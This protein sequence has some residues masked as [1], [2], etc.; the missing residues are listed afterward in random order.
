MSDLVKDVQKQEIS[1]G[2]IFLFDLEYISGS[3]ARFY[4]G[5]SEDSENV[6]FRDSSGNVVTYEALPIEMEGIDIASDGSYN[7]PVISVANL[8]SIFS[9]AIGGLSYEELI[10]KR[11]TRRTTLEKYLVGGTGDSGAGNAPVEFPKATYVIDRIKSK[12]LLSVSFELAAPFDLAGVTLPRRVI[13]GGSCPFKYRGAA[14]NVSAQDKIG[15]CNWSQTIIASDVSNVFMNKFDEYIVPASLF[16]GLSNFSGT[17]TAGAYYITTESQ[18]QV[19]KTS[20]STQN[21]T[22]YWQALTATSNS[23]ADTDIINWRRVRVFTT[24]AGGSTYYAYRDARYSN[25]VLSSGKLW[26]VGK[27]SQIG[28]SHDPLKE[29]LY[30][31]EG[32][33]CGKKVKSCSKRFH[34]QAHSTL[35]GGINVAESKNIALPFGGF[36]GA[37]QSR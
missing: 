25:Y 34:A 22:A 21:I 32:D 17:A 30:W 10:G 23:P 9:A 8:G 27:F 31:T 15:G 16:S 33:I 13:I 4:A 12:N 5:V 20:S 26:Q 1:S 6:Q 7:R 35:T 37:R 18:T 2:Y 24:Y 28:A 19:N 3:F 11:V 36:P 29:G 14:S